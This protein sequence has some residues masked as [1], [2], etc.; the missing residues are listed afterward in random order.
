M[1][2]ESE[3]DALI[4]ILSIEQSAFGCTRGR[5]VYAY[6]MMTFPQNK[7]FLSFSFAYIINIPFCF[8]RTLAISL[9]MVCGRIG[10]LVGNVMF[11]IL[12]DMACVI[13]FFTMSGMMIGE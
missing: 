5:T 10:T 9:M 3:R 7:N 1:G 11:P 8:F 6:R 2:G 12:L 13:P 4:I